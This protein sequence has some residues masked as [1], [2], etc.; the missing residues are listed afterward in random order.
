LREK[1]RAIPIVEPEITHS[2]GLVVPQ[3][4]PLTP[5]INTLVT[6]AKQLAPILSAP[7]EAAKR[8]PKAGR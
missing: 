8:G 7:E 4:N 1:L 3:R 6:E 5:L 2:I